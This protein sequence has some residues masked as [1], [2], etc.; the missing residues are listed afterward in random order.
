MK[1]VRG[2]LIEMALRGEFEVIVHGCNC[3]CTMGAGIAARIR[4][5]FPA[6]FK[7]D[8]TTVSGDR[9]KLGTCSWAKCQI[10]DRSGPGVLVVNAY[11]QYGFRQHIGDVVVD[12]DAV[13]GCMRWVVES[14]VISATARIGMPKIGAG[15]AGGDW[16]RVQ[17]IIEDE[18]GDRDVTIVV[19]DPRGGSA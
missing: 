1:T 2:D 15:L 6:A 9:S 5:V 14:G 19:Y 4:D 12:Y 11:T 13:R 18:L 7:T 10:R 3:F 8:C 17:S 16:K